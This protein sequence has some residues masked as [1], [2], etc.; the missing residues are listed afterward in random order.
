MECDNLGLD[1]SSLF[2][3]FCYIFLLYDLPVGVLCD[4][5]FVMGS[6]AAAA[7]AAAAKPKRE[8]ARA[9]PA[10]LCDLVCLAPIPPAS[11]PANI[12]APGD[13]GGTRGIAFELSFGA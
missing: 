5:F 1:A 3:V 12:P 4:I 8:R 11:F 13:A 7:P 6:E 10:F 9:L 2:S